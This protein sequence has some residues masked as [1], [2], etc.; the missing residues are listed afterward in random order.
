MVGFLGCQGHQATDKV[1]AMEFSYTRHQ[2]PR[3]S[4]ADA[5]VG[6]KLYLIKSVSGLR[7]TYQIRVLAFMA[8]ERSKKLIVQLPKD[9][10][11]HES[12]RR[13]VRD[14]EGLIKIERA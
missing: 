2:T 9:A 4:K 10:K 6:D 1:K 13:F 5:E 12:L 8:H 14:S 11:V 3:G 7:L